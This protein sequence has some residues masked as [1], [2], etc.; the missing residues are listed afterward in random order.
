MLS[1]FNPLKDV[2][3]RLVQELGYSRGQD[4]FAAP[5]DFRKSP[6]ANPEWKRDTKRLIEDAS[7]MNGGRPVTIICHSL[8]GLYTLHLLHSMEEKWVRKCHSKHLRCTR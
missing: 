1:W 2:V 3:E 4:I 8:G 5:Y 6:E 7:A